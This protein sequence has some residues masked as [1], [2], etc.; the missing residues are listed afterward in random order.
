MELS[1]ITA[2]G[3]VFKPGRVVRPE[4][5]NKPFVGCIIELQRRHYQDKT[6]AQKIEVRV[7]CQD[8][9]DLASR[10]TEGAYILVA[11]SGDVYLR[12]GEGGKHYAN[13]RV[14]ANSVTF[15][16]PCSPSSNSPS[17]A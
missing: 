7:Y 14:T 11:G 16:D 15:I 12:E 4:N 17:M 6:F 1:H 2:A 8:P 5:G 13:L 10:L 3:R 9:D